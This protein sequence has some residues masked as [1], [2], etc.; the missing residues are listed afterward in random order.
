MQTVDPMDILNHLRT[1]R[2]DAVVLKNKPAEFD[3]FK[4]S[5]AKPTFYQGGER[6]SYRYRSQSVKNEESDPEDDPFAEAINLNQD[7]NCSVALEKNQKKKTLNLG[8]LL[9]RRSSAWDDERK[10]RNSDELK[11][12]RKNDSIFLDI[13]APKTD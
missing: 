11:S 3:F 8:Q 13:P 9:G 7:L 12:G 1:V 10:N 6:A 4:V 2:A 5:T